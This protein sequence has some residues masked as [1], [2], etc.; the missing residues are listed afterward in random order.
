VGVSICYEDARFGFATLCEQFQGMLT[1]TSPVKKQPC[2]AED[3]VHQLRGQ[4]L[5]IHGMLD[6]FT[7][8]TGT[9]RLIDALQQA[10]KDFDMLLL[11]EEGHDIPNYALRRSWD[12]FV[13]HLHGI[14]PP[15]EFS[16]TI[17][18]DLLLSKLSK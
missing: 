4:L 8:V 5:L 1:E 3:L 14:E 18:I 12:Y 11:P 9:V 15:S 7:P 13:I 10:N 2:Y 16:L 6:Q 17:G